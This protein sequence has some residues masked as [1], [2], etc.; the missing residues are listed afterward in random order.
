[1]PAPQPGQRGSVFVRWRGTISEK[2]PMGA[3]HM[4]RGSRYMLV[5]DILD[6]RPVSGDGCSTV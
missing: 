6:I 3:G 1:M 5:H 2:L 4:G